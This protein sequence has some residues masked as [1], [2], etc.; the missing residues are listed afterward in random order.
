M[1]DLKPNQNDAPAAA[2]PIQYQQGYQQQEQPVQFQQYQPNQIQYQQQP[3]YQPVIYQQ[4]QPNQILYQQQ[5]QQQQVNPSINF[6]LNPMDILYNAVSAYIEQKF[7]L[8]EVLASCETPNQYYIS[9]KDAEG[10]KH[11]L[12]KAK[13]QSS[14]CCRIFCPGSCRKFD[15]NLNMIMT[16]SQ[17]Q[18]V[19]KEFIKFSRPF[20]CT[21]CCWGRPAM[22]A[23]YVDT[24]EIIG[25]MKEPYTVCGP[26][27]YVYDL[28]GSI[29]YTIH[30]RCCQCG[31]CCRNNF[32]GRCS[33]CEF[34]IY[35]KTN[36][37]GDPVGV[38]YKKV[39]GIESI[40]GDA[41]FYNIKFPIGATVEG[42]LLL[43][44]AVIMIDYLYYEEK[45]DDKPSTSVRRT[46]GF[47]RPGFGYGY[48][49]GYGYGI[50]VGRR[51]FF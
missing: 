5:Q 17:G 21:C 41:D 48:G 46:I 47:G 43:I 28:N 50:R 45:D 34:D 25:K 13:E 51:G 27:V 20:K 24:H 38:V 9:T 39:K 10:N 37:N 3:Q 11:Y 14:C 4:Y 36:I 30:I 33:P 31:Y 1:S 29:I 2:G 12:F 18:Q 26:Q 44:G 35:E 16:S 22:T 40:I 23:E 7:E 19:K 49:Y 32:C 42:K 15:I 6:V 8:L